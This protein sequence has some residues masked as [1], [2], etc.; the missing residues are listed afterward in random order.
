M[1][2]N[3][4]D[5]HRA[6]VKLARPPGILISAAGT[7]MIKSGDKEAVLALLLDDLRG[8]TGDEIE[9]ILP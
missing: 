3:V 8:H 1:D 9:R 2:A 7:A 5:L 6:E 4:L